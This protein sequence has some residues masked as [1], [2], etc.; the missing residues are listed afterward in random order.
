MTNGI[1]E[2]DG[3][4]NDEIIIRVFF[5]NQYEVQLT[6]VIYN[7]H[8]RHDQHLYWRKKTKRYYVIV[9]AF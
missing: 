5:L 2:G 7:S 3:P 1:S 9:C 4:P 6:N 8:M